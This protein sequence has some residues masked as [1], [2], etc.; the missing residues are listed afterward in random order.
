MRC[1]YVCCNAHHSCSHPPEVSQLLPLL[2]LFSRVLVLERGSCVEDGTPANLLLQ[3]GGHLNET[4]LASPPRLQAHVRRMLALHRTRVLPAVRGLWRSVNLQ[5]PATLGIH[6]TASAG[7]RTFESQT[8]GAGYHTGSVHE[9]TFG[10][11]GK[12]TALDESPRAVPIH[13]AG[14]QPVDTPRRRG[15]RKESF[16]TR[17]LPWSSV[18]STQSA[19]PLQLVASTPQPLTLPPPPD[20]QMP[21]PWSFGRGHT[22]AL[23]PTQRAGYMLLDR[24]ADLRS[25]NRQSVRRHAAAAAAPANVTLSKV[26]VVGNSTAHMQPTAFLEDP[27]ASRPSL[28][29]PLGTRRGGGG[30]KRPQAFATRELPWAVLGNPIC[31]HQT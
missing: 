21:A 17:T 1:V 9:L 15:W 28:L 25:D 10:R 12:G 5:R 20:Q 30:N 27:S 2:H 14:P 16:V 24:F 22:S 29:K 13:A 11:A 23:Y 18:K 26:G 7:N 8:A 3:T 6:G 19:V 4:F 31:Y